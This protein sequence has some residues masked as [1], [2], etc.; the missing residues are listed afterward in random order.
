MSKKKYELLREELLELIRK[1]GLNP[2]DKLPTVRDIIKDSNFS[3]ATVHRTIIEMENEGLIIARQGKGLYVGNVSTKSAA[4]QVAL[5]IPSQISGY[6]IFI[7]IVRGIRSVLEEKEVSLLISISDLSHEKEKVTIERLISGH[8]KGIIIFL[9]DH[10]RED[11]SHIAKLKE[12][13]FPFVLID[14]HIPELQTDYVV[15]DNTIAMHRICA[16][17]KYNR[18]CDKIIF[19]PS[20]GLIS[21]SSTEDKIAGFKQAVRILYEDEEETII[22]QD[23]LPSRL[24]EMSKQ[25]KNL[26]ISLNHD[27]MLLELQEALEK[28]N[29]KIPANCHFF[30]YNNSF[31][32]PICPTVEQF[33]D[34]VGAKAAEILIEK[35][36]NQESDITQIK[37]KPKLVLPDANG[38]FF[39]ED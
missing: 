26:G 25:Y 13:K 10:Y 6:R 21:V 34:R 14:R 28:K 7:D 16:Y 19:V 18:N 29:K 1:K 11:Y 37:I 3:Y 33:N 31:E 35:L 27:G 32:T 4:Q 9:E 2:N 24:D 5:I 38:N 22:G 17:L 12:A 36:E 39:M 20:P 8:V 15:V 30:G 23:E